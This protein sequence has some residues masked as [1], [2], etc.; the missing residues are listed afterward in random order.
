MPEAILLVDD[1]PHLMH[2]LAMF[3]DLEGYHVLKARD[4][5]QALDLLREYQPDLVLLDLMMPGVSGLDVCKQI[6]ADRKLKH[7]P[8]MVFTAAETRE[9]ELIAAG[10][11]K[12]IAKPYSLEGLRSAVKDL[13]ESPRG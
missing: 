9:E 11:T 10:A 4:G 2:V 7:V 1:D 12:F 5:Q 6:R 8:V 13:L 3:F